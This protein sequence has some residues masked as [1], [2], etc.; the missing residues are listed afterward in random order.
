MLQNLCSD[1]LKFNRSGGHV[2][3]AHRSGC[4]VFITVRDTGI[5][6][7]KEQIDDFFSRQQPRSLRDFDGEKARI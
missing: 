1:A 6:M 5:G 3:S 2:L 7:T 4:E